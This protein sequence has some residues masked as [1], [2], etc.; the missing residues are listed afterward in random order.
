M[1]QRD[2]D[3]ERGAWAIVLLIVAIIIGALKGCGG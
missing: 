2:T 3:I 1:F